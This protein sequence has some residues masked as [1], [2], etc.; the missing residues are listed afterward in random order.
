MIVV[1]GAYGFI[2]SCLVS[3][4]AIKANL[5]VLAVDDFSRSEKIRN[6]PENVNI[7]KVGRQSLWNYLAENNPDIQWFIHLGA[8]TDTVEKNESIFDKLNLAYSKNV[9]NYCT[10]NQIPLI[11]ASSAATYGDGEYGFVDNHA[12]IPRLKPMNPYGWSKQEFDLWVLSRS[13][14][15]PSWIGLKFFNVYGP[16]ESH[17]GRMASVIYHAYM[18]IT[19]KGY[20]T[21]FKSHR[22]EIADGE[23][24]RDFIYVKD[25]IYTITWL[26]R[27]KVSNGIYN[28]GSGKARS[29]RAL[30]EASFEAMGKSCDIKYIDTPIDIRDNYQYYTQASMEKLSNQGLNLVFTSL[31]KGVGDYII[32]YLLQDNMYYDQL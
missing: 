19:Q 29:F 28:L 6:L 18:Q 12:L 32:N 5:L 1:T 16:N 14:Q 31:E 13:E 21:L 8:R 3:E 11:Y 7:V 2:G 23:Q 22:D 24:T 26:M 15:P 4:L 17:K 9:W 30:T 27:N 10:E 25:V 20:M